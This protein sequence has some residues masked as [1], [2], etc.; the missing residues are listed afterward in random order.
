M[1]NTLAFSLDG[2]SR[3]VFMIVLLPTVEVL[4]TAAAVIWSCHRYIRCSAV[5]LINGNEPVRKYRNRSGKS[6]PGSLY[7]NLI[8][9][10]LR[11]DIGREVVSVVTIVLCVFIVGFGIDIKLAYEGALRHQMK[12]IWKYDII[13]TESGK[14]TDEEREIVQKELA[15]LNTLYIPVSAGVI[16]IGDS[17]ILTNIICVHDQEE[18]A[19]FYTLKDDRGIDVT[20]PQNGVLVT[21]EMEDK[22]G[23]HP[24]DTINLVGANLDYSQVD[25]L[26]CFCCMQGKP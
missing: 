19:E 10:N 15:D 11:T 23:I 6:L 3:N 20:I 5:G 25:G 7:I 1:K 9:N 22:N 21:K 14:I 18:F 24:G 4:I 16:S 12:D 8:I 17:Q 13:L 2:V 26:V